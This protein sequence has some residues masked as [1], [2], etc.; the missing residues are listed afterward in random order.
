MPINNQSPT[1]GN[2]VFSGGSSTPFIPSIGNI[3]P[4]RVIDIS[5]SE[6]SNPKSLFQIS[7]KWAGIGAIR[8][9]L[10]NK[11]SQPEDFPQGNIAYP[12]DNN[13]KKLPLIGEVVFITPGPSTR[14]LTENNS[15]AIDFYY[16]NAANI[17]GRSHLNLFPSLNADYS[18]DTNV[19]NNSQVELGLEN[20]QDTPIKE[21]K[22]GRTFVEKNN[23][24]NLWPV[25]GDIILEGRWGN[26][27]RFS[28]TAKAPS[29]SIYR[30]PW[31]DAGNSGDPITIL[32]NGQ[33]QV[34]L[35]I[36]NWYPIYEDISTDDSSIYMTS[37]QRI[38]FELAST[39]FATF[40]VDALSGTNTTQLL[41]DVPLDNPNKSNK[42]ADSTGSIS[43][44]IEI[45]PKL[46]TPDQTTTLQGN[47]IP[48]SGSDISG[49]K[50][51]TPQIKID[52][53]IL[54][55]FDGIYRIYLVGKDL[56]SVSGE[57][58]EP[59]PLYNNL[60]SEI[61]KLNPNKELDFLEFK[62][63]PIQG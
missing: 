16:L 24:R 11:G 53:T 54:K 21:P 44:S 50:K 28:S 30:N 26:S 25:E 45:Q 62:N 8:F 56:I 48:V 57:S 4:A 23:I 12:L 39:N 13:F 5:L 35:P 58:F 47:I 52:V 55:K 32:R 17:W 9:E 63:V 40:G 10:I 18:T 1:I 15:N 37:K 34:D 59:E 36:N 38:E 31:S 42:E 33:S 43:D 27:L 51:I 19:L 2:S 22:P 6:N 61:I 41:Q 3:F 20:N 49:L 29:G 7:K 14:Q 60:I 46:S